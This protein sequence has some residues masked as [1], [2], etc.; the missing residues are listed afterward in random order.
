MAKFIQDGKIIDFKNTGES[1]I[2][3]GDIVTL[4]THVGV[5]AEKINIGE[6]GGV[7]TEGVFEVEAITTAAFNVGDTLYLD[8][9]KKATNVK[10]SLTVVIGYAVQEKVTSSSTAHVKLG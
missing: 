3:Y 7:R 4:G 6:V 9:S 1:T 5:A 10:G 2:N 8:E